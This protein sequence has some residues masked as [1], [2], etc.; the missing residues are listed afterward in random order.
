MKKV[1]SLLLVLVMICSL[2]AVSI[3]ATTDYTNGTAVVYD[4]TADNDGDGN[5]DATEAWTVTVPATM[6]PG[7]TAEV[8]AEGTWASNRK[9]T[10]TADAAV[11]LTNSINANDTKVLDVTF[12]GIELAGSNTEAVEATE[13]LSIE[14]IADALFG[15][16]TGHIDYEVEMSD[17]K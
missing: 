10:V 4:A 6:A 8:H 12:A 11:T 13:E 17:V 2:G 9:L 14:D 16:W 7:E 1:V 3:F 5:P 15:T